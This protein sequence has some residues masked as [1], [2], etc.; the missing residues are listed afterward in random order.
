M[1]WIVI[2]GG[3]CAFGT[4]F[5][6]GANDVANAFA[7]SIGSKSLTLKQAI[8][9][10]SIMEFLGAVLL[11]ANVSN[12]I[13]KSIVSVDLFKDEPELLMLGMLSSIIGTGVW[14]GISTYLSLPV[15]TTH[16]VVGAILGFSLVANGIN[17][18]N[19]FTFAMIIV[20]WF[21]SPIL[22]GILSSIGF[23]T[24]RK[25]IM[26][27]SDSTERAIRYYPLLL[28]FTISI[29]VF[30][31]IYK[32]TPALKLDKVPLWMAIVI[33][34]SV[35]ISLSILSYCLITPYLKKKFLEGEPDIELIT[36]NFRD[37]HQEEMNNIDVLQIHNNSEKFEP[38]TEKLFTYLQI[39][40]A[41][42]DS[43][44]H[45]ANDVANSIGPYAAIVSIYYTMEVNSKIPIPVWILVL[46]GI[47][48]SIGLAVYGYNIIKTIGIRLTTITPVRG[49]NIELATSFI[50]VL[51]SRIGIPVST[52]H[53][54]VGATIST[55]LVE[56][57]HQI[58]KPT[59]IKILF[60]WVITLVITGGI[61]GLIYFIAIQF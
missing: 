2:I 36:D 52:T 21:V 58:H 28:F 41:V 10:A 55:G 15:S 57:V 39:M 37:L 33:S 60:G 61:S 48:I 34:I 6:I 50:V 35:G 40:T 31:V 9:I 1:L 25:F 59:L 24:I 11:G 47:G 5:F 8:V 13:R 27:K 18:V 14:L 17:G 53:C 23:A 49:F 46:G 54:Q 44:A 32:G 30:F 7:T 19:W 29:N 56:G 20:S 3:I 16:S 51:A 38:K 4:S 12:T 42:L 43:F 22:S 26:R 45:G